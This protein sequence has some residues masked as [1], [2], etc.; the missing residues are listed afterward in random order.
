MHKQRGQ[1]GGWVG[2]GWGLGGGE[3]YAMLCNPLL[4]HFCTASSALV[5][6]S[7][8]MSVEWPRN[9]SGVDAANTDG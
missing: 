4:A 6:N 9:G 3:M 8:P 2:A 7:I 1:G 5:W